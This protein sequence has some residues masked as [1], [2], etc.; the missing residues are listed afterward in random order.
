MTATPDLKKTLA[1]IEKRLPS[2]DVPEVIE[3]Q[4]DNALALELAAKVKKAKKMIT[5]KREFY[6]KP[7]Y[8]EYKRVRKE[9]ARFLDLLD[10]KEKELKTAMLAFHK[11]E[12]KRLD[13]EQARI[14][15]EALAKAADGEAVEVTVVNDIKTVEGI[16]GKS[17][18]RKIKKWKVVDITKVPMEYL[19]VDEKKVKEAIKKGKVPAGIE[20]YYED[21]LAI[22]T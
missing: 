4:E 1:T 14:D 16:H 9:F 17:T 6:A 12:Q 5:D 2:Y 7:F 11:K 21:S 20:E 15:K 8:N 13:A 18:V 10:A 19:C 3:T 22:N